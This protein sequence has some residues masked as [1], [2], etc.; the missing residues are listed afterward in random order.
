MEGAL[1]GIRVVDVTSGPVG[2][3]ATMVLADY[4][5]D[6]I[7]V[8]PPGGDRFRVLAAAPLWLR[9]KRSVVL[10]LSDAPARDR[11]QALVASADV[12]VVSGPPSRAARWGVA[13]EDV[14]ARRPGIVHCS[15]TGWGPR[16]RFAEMPAYD[17]VVAA[18]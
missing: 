17:G 14:A 13:F 7:K 18:L 12:L 16:G 8:E 11:L 4:G 2:G 9:G 15:I 6:V 1:D 3:I 10:D 5:A